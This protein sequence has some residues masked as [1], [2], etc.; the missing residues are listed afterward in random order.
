[1]ATSRRARTYLDAT[2]PTTAED[3]DAGYVVGDVWVDTSGPTIYVCS[4]STAGAAQWT[5]VSAGGGGGGGVPTSRTISTTAPLTGGGNLTADR[6]LGIS[7]FVAS[8]ASAARGAVPV[9]PGVAGTALFLRED[10]TWADPDTD[11]VVNSTTLATTTSTTTG[12]A[13]PLTITFPSAGT[14]IYY[15]ESTHS[16]SIATSGLRCSV[17]ATGGLTASEVSLWTHAFTLAGVNGSG[18]FGFANWT[19]V[20]NSNASQNPFT[21]GGRIV[22]TA[23]GTLTLWIRSES[24]GATANLYGGTMFARRIA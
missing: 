13:T 17:Q 15:G 18:Q 9:P 11:L 6:T 14:W 21:F 23:A 19:T 10:A 12:V 7:D 4:D 2:A 5:D 22:V 8:G 1:M 20:T 16:C 3:A 24:V